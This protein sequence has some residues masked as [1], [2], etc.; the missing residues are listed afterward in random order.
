MFQ[1]QEESTDYEYPRGPLKRY[2]EEEAILQA[3]GS[4]IG[5]TEHRNVSYYSHK[6]TI[7]A[8]AWLN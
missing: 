1:A 3:N 7:W 5:F 2:H 8:P 4:T 6:L